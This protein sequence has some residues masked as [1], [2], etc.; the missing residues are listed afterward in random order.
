[1]TATN[2]PNGQ[3]AQTIHDFVFSKDNNGLRASLAAG[4]KVNELDE[5]GLTPL[6]VGILSG[7][8][9][10]VIATLLANDATLPPFLSEQAQEAWGNAIFM[11]NNIRSSACIAARMAATGRLKLTQEVW[12]N[13]LKV[14]LDRY[15]FIRSAN[16]EANTDLLALQP[17]A[18][19]DILSVTPASTVIGEALWLSARSNNTRAC[20][21]LLSRPGMSPEMLEYTGAPGASSD[22]MLR[23]MPH[24]LPGRLPAAALAIAAAWGNVDLVKQLA[25]A[26][27]NPDG[28]PGSFPPLAAAAIAN[29]PEVISA[30]LSAGANINAKCKDV[31]PPLY[32]AVAAGASFESI[33][34][35]LNAGALVNEPVTSRMLAAVLP[36]RYLNN[37][38]APN[39]I[40]EEYSALG[41]LLDTSASDM[42][43][44]PAFKSTPADNLS[45][46]AKSLLAAGASARLSA[47]SSLIVPSM[48]V[49]AKLGPD[50][51]SAVLCAGASPSQR[52]A[53]GKTI[54]HR[55]V[56]EQALGMLVN[57]GADINAV[58]KEGF[59]PLAAAV[60]RATFAGV[61]SVV[62]GS[63]P[64]AFIE[65]DRLL[66]AGALPDVPSQ[67]ITPLSIASAHAAAE[68]V[69]RLLAAGADVNAR[70]D[71]PPGMFTHSVH[72]TALTSLLFSRAPRPNKPKTLASLLK[73]GADKEEPNRSGRTPLLT[74]LCMRS[75]PSLIRQMIAA[76]ANVNATVDR[77]TFPMSMN[78]QVWNRWGSGDRKGVLGTRPQRRLDHED[79]HCRWCHLH[80]SDCFP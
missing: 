58:S 44:A 6:A 4:A 9:L 56:P 39:A 49:A 17:V 50:I 57:A 36:E 79:A 7:T 64:K 59:T 53:N 77:S 73:A 46:I 22:M 26:G 71:F 5:H 52:E 1:M 24:G 34:S 74:M 29:H 28:P 12:L 13:Q 66:A 20:L 55:A 16:D 80:A 62:N 70:N 42:N 10:D 31:L 47:S 33:K 51:L 48:A 11:N 25:A 76:G 27:A 54:L 67:A 3:V 38:G 60:L 61:T 2:A 23:A 35:L 41:V 75:S 32:F 78:L 21:N 72:E 14:L 43:F 40:L 19:D 68:I 45:R 65:I 37:S 63:D 30:L 15:S 8:S 18:I 69:D